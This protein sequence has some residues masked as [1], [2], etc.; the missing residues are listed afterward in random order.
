MT[1]RAGLLTVLGLVLGVAPLAASDVEPHGGMLRYPDVSADRIVFSYADD[2]WLVPR[3]G[4]QAVPL[5]SPRG[6]EIFPRFAPDGESV[7]FVGNYDGGRDLYVMPTRGGIPVQVTHHPANEVLCDFTPDG[8]LLFAQN[9]RGGLARQIQLFTVSPTGGLPVRLAVPY[10]ANGA[11]SADGKW[12]AYT[13]HPRDFATWKRYRGGWATDIWVFGLEDGSARLITDWEGTDTLPM[14]H[15]D[16]VYYL[17]DAGPT[18][19]LNL[20]AYDTGSGKR[21]QVTRYDDYDVKWPAIGP[22]RTG[23]GEIVFQYGSGIHLLDLATD[24]VTRVPVTVPGA[25]PTLRPQRV[26]AG[27]LVQSWN[28]SPTAQR[29]LLGARGDIWTVPVK[30][31]TPRDLTRTAG[32]AERWPAWSPDGRFI[33]YFSDATGEY[34]LYVR[35]ADG[36]GEARQLTRDNK[37]FFLEPR[38]SPDSKKLAFYDKAGRLLLYDFDAEAVREIDRNPWAFPST[39]TFS[40]DSRW[41]AYSKGL[42]NL[43]T[44]IF[45]YD[46]D[47]STAHRVTSGMF[48]DSNPLFDRKGEFLYYVSARQFSDPLYEDVGTTFVYAGVGRLLAVPLNAEVENPFAPKSDEE[49]PD[50]DKDENGDDDKKG[51][52]D[53]K[54]KGDKKDKKGKDKDGDKDEEDEDETEEPEPVKID[55]EGFEA[56]AVVLPTARGSFG[57]LASAEEGELVFVR[58]PLAPGEDA[59]PSIRIFDPR[60]EEKEREEKTVLEGARAFEMSADGKKILAALENSYVL[61]DPKPDQKPED[62]VSLQGMEALVDPRAEWN[63]IFHDAWRIQRDYFYVANMHGVDWEAVRRQYETML[64][65][66]V[67]RDDVSYVISEMIAELNIGHAYYFGGDVEEQ[68]SRE[69][70]MLGV[71]LEV[72][73]GAY[74]I[75]RILR[76][77]AWD[78]DVRGPLDR[79]DLEV[80]E[81]DYILAVNGMT[82]DVAQDPWLPLVGL[83]GKTVTLTVS[84]KPSRDADAREI[85]VTTLDLGGEIALRYR[86]WVED[87]RRFV[88][89]QTDGRVGYIHVPNTGVDGQNELFRQFYGQID[90]GALII[91][92]RWNAG[93]Q[94]PTRFIELLNRPRTNY[95]YRR[96][97]KDWPWPPDSHQGPKCM[98]INGPSG[99]GGDAFPWYFRRAGLGPLIGGRT[100]GGLVGLSGNPGLIDGGYMSVPTFGFYETDGTWGVEGHGVDPDIPVVDDPAVMAK[101]KDPQLDRA[102]AEMLAAL[103]AH[104][105]RPP[106]RPTPP[107][108]SGMGLPEEDR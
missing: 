51:K 32:V 38:F 88:A 36:S 101:G 64:A 76:G 73:D 107:D 10:G 104:P 71:D 68:P 49:A 45:V 47:S 46:L 65:D 100:W 83:A 57:T 19:R 66:C 40:P 70:G 30:H 25:R 78:V 20:W 108:R 54:S 3:T 44:A 75:A 74:R 33:A 14:W 22:G 105:Y 13:L 5:A 50:G 95:W 84:K 63:Q 91:D 17:S 11:V 93:G 9:G 18:H 77:G 2:L 67:S 89:Q 82:L 15:G 34:E 43:A 90:R 55:L 48:N 26:D 58:F 87:N 94:I 21:R 96:D 99:S 41:L 102:I 42:D 80:G 61:V 106:A 39:L 24:E 92:E 72:R 53:D 97:G 8:R 29:M 1:L 62:T 28:V 4:G 27:E 60:A 12:L 103:E 7:A 79:S 86:A 81:G 16:V 52:G 69:V 85:V 35:P 56:R 31:G 59:K 98:L 23:K 6:P 37:T